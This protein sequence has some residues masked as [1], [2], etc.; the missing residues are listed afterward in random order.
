MCV[1]ILARSRLYIVYTAV[2]TAGGS[3]YADLASVSCLLFDG[4]SPSECLMAPL[5][6]HTASDRRTIANPRACARV[7]RSHDSCV[8]DG[9]RESWCSRSDVGFKCG[10]ISRRQSAT[11]LGFFL[12]RPILWRPRRQTERTAKLGPST[13]TESLSWPWITKQADQDHARAKPI[14]T[15]WRTKKQRK[16]RNAFRLSCDVGPSAPRRRT[17]T[18]AISSAWRLLHSRHVNWMAW[19]IVNCLSSQQK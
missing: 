8:V 10:A 1:H 12:D 11:V 7:L 13:N 17:K 16:S 5:Q 9:S 14:T 4:S 19:D 3:L 18:E 6:A 2:S 15:L